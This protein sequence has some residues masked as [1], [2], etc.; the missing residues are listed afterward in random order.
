MYL[1]LLLQRY[2]LLCYRKLLRSKLLLRLSCLGMRIYK[3]KVWIYIGNPLL[4]KLLLNFFWK[5][6]DI[7][8]TTDYLTGSINDNPI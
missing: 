3:G 8:L 7:L 4:L 5:V 2:L 6:F 1:W